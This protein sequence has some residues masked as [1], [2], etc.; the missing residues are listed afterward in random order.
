MYLS[1]YDVTIQNTHDIVVDLDRLRRELKQLFLMEAMY[2][3]NTEYFPRGWEI[4]K[5]KKDIIYLETELFER[6][7]LK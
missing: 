2:I 6:S 1:E 7:F 5:T 4:R 3:G